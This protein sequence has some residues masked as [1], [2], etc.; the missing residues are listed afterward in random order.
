MPEE[1]VNK[2]SASVSGA[3]ISLALSSSCSRL[4]DLTWGAAAE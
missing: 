4:G 3:N 1:S 2:D